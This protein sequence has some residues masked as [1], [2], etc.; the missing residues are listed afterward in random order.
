MWWTCVCDGGAPH[1]MQ[2]W[3]RMIT[4]LRR[5]TG[6]TGGCVHLQWY[7]FVVE[8]DFGQRPITRHL[9][10]GG[11]AD[12][13]G[14]R[15]GCW[16]C[17]GGDGEHQLGTRGAGTVDARTQRG[18]VEDEFEGVG[19]SLVGGASVVCA[20]GFGSWA[21]AFV[22]H[23]Q[24]LLTDDL[25][26]VGMDFDASVVADVGVDRVQRWV[27]GR[28]Y[29]GAGSVGERAGDGSGVLE[30]F[31]RCRTGECLAEEFDLVPG[32]L[33]FGNGLGATS[34]DLV[35]AADDGVDHLAGQSSVGSMTNECG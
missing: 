25:G 11:L 20:V 24:E 14:P 32:A 4:A 8:D 16:V 31:C 35:P 18:L 6:T 3:S 22:D 9:F 12:G 19:A 23:R 17:G 30:H 27:V 21:G 28:R 1:L 34:L 5:W 29:T 7:A 26:Q 13:S 15:Q 2:N 10:R 33:V